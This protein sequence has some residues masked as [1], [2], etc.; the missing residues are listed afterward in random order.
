MDPWA[1]EIAVLS[2][3]GYPLVVIVTQEEQRALALVESA[4][5]AARKAFIQW[6][7][8]RGYHSSARGEPDE[9]AGQ[10]EAALRELSERTDPGL[11]VLLDFGAF[12]GRPEVV[13]RLR[14][15]LPDLVRRRQSVVMVGPTGTL[16]P[17][18]DQDAVRVDLPLPHTGLL[19]AELTRVAEAE[20]VNVDPAVAERAVRSALG[21]S[22]NEANRVFRKVMVLRRGLAEPDLHLI[23][24]AKKRALRTTDVL[25]FHELGERLSDVGGLG[26]LK[27]WLQNRTRAFGAEAQAFG[28]PPPKGLLLLGVQGCG[29]SLSAKAVAE[30]W[31][32][33][34]LRLDLGA[35]FAGAGGSPEAAL[36]QAIKISESLSPVV[37]WVDEIE[38]G[39][40]QAE[41]GESSSRVFGSFLTWLS[42]KRAE[43][44]VVATANNVAGLP[45]ELLRRGRFDEVFFVDLPNVH[46]R[47]EILRIHLEKRGRDPRAF[48]GFDSVAERAEYFSG[49]ELEQVVI[50]GLYRAFGEGRELT[51]EDLDLARQQTV[52]LYTT[53]EEQIKALRDWARTRA[54][55]ATL[56]AS[57]L[58]LFGVALESGGL[59]TPG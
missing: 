48:G 26:E 32:F 41:G 59:G 42:E 29:K 34:L 27:R 37:L 57:V 31:K 7:I 47:Q 49:A 53:Y 43:V 44:F 20:R 9:T 18:L 50:A 17:E 3:A 11:V 6:S 15:R 35:V 16:P 52:P 23:V 4:A 39:F 12:L 22:L 51:V 54:R 13:R 33:P 2:R 45:P 25:E 40:A 58:D 19:T 1:K 21:L 30:L 5:Q 14:D 28:L 55:P 36:R 56:D 10:P 38:K 46:E 24:D 8:S